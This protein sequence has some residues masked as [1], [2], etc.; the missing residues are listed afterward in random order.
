MKE[1]Y[2]K[3]PNTAYPGKNPDTRYWLLEG[4][5]DR[6][7]Y[8]GQIELESRLYQVFI[9][10]PPKGKNDEEPFLRLT[11]RALNEGQ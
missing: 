10:V 7:Y 4:N 5:R 6:E 2:F 11:L 3:Q 8:N 1:E 9:R